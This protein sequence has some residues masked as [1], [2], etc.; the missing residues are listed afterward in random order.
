MQ[1]F[2]EKQFPVSKVS[3]ESYKE[4]KSSQGQTITGLGKWWGRKPLVLVRAAIL[5]CLMPASDN[6]KRDMEIFLKIMSMDNNGLLLRKEKT[7][8]VQE[9]Y[10]IASKDKK[11][12]SYIAQWFDLT[13]SKIKLNPGVDKKEVEKRI[14]NSLGYDQKLTKCKR[15]EQLENLDP[16]TWNEINHHLG[17]NAKSLQELTQ[18][19]SVKRFGKN[20]RVGDCFCGG[21]SIP[22]E[23]ARMG[24]DT[25]ASDL[26]PIAGLLTWASINICGASEEELAEIKKF[27]QEV[28]DKV[29][30]EITALGIEQN[31][32]G[33]RALTYLYCVEAVCPECGMKVPMLPSLVVGIRAGK[34]VAKLSPNGQAYDITIKMNVTADEMKE[35]EKAGTATSRGMVCPHC[36]KNTP[37]TAL[38]KDRRDE[39]GNTVYGLRLWEKG[40]FDFREDDVYSERLYAIR[41][42]RS[43]GTRFYRA[44]NERDLQNEV[45]VKQIVADNIVAWQEQGLVPSMEI[46]D[47]DK[48][49]E[50]IRNRG[51]THWN[52]LFNARQLLINSLF[53]KYIMQETDKKRK[54]IGILN[55]NKTVDRNSRLCV[56]HSG[57]DESENTFYNQALNTLMNW[58]VRS[59]TMLS[60]LWLWTASA[61]PINRNAKVQLNDARDISTDVDF[62]ITDPPYA[63]AV[64]Y[65][66][67]SEFFLAWDKR[68][69][70][71]AFPEWYTD[72]K[73]ILA[74]KGDEHFS[75]SM[76]EIYSNLT[77]HMDNNGLQV[78][79]FTHSDSAV[80]AQLALIMWKAGLKVSAAWN[81]ATETES[82]GLKD[83]NYVKGTVLLVLRKQTGSDTAYLDEINVDI[84]NEVKV[85]IESMQALDDKEE[86]NFS[87]P[88]YV[89]AAYAA[90]LKVLTSYK[91]IGELDL[92]YELNLAIN[93]PAKSKVVS[94][95]ERAKKIAFDFIIPTD[96][97]SY[98]WKD[99]SSAERFYIKGLE[100]EKRGNYQIS[101][102]QEFARGFAIGSYSQLMANEKANTARLKTP[103]EFAMRSLNEVP[104]FESSTLRLILAAIHIAIKE[105]GRPEKGL[106]HIKNNL[107]DYWGSRDMI[108][109]LLEFLKDTKD[110]GN[111]PH[112][113]ESAEMADHLYVLVE[114]DHI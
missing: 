41:Y 42:E 33:D 48:T 90:S 52:H 28:F 3:K 32:H 37:I 38:R 97:E 65:H 17:T 59:L 113:A 95:I 50:V 8:S 45:K 64:N 47:G 46:E 18:Q 39:N 89:L 91:N 73:R 11:L 82:G 103:V 105:D 110:I 88:D 21:G 96:F 111:M 77:K 114:N 79:M 80:W 56:W 58:G 49:K 26:N 51:W 23:A 63:D 43:D 30:R 61:Y 10:D 67:L 112:W 70:Q 57:R 1:S 108:K 7:F 92:D 109:Q 100:G 25:Y 94:L 31:E 16:Q 76:I 13:G 106:F 75:R 85:Q 99:M 2:I 14:F 40:D 12:S 84:K 34:V 36:R 98:L 87:D 93:D 15:P 78:V 101:T 5:G 44:P 74:I 68:L 24:C 29:D 4:R 62:W 72:S 20:V 107:P 66:E 22:F 71:E 53:M 9:M 6:P 27:Q 81:I 86:P 60:T 83:G 69:L 35:A 102:Y 104:D 54:V 55:L 19:L